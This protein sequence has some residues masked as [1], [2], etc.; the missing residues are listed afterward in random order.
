[1]VEQ[2]SELHLQKMKLYIIHDKISLRKKRVKYNKKKEDKIPPAIVKQM[3]REET[4][5]R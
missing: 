4:A 3:T 1:M 2:S 5:A